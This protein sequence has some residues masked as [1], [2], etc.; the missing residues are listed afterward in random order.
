M[1]KS[2]QATLS[3]STQII[4]ETVGK[5]ADKRNVRRALLIDR[6]SGLLYELQTAYIYRNYAQKSLNTHRTILKNLAFFNEWISIKRNRNSKW[7]S[8]EE[9]VKNNQLALTRKE[10][11]DFSRW[12]QLF[13]HEVANTRQKETKSIRRIPTGKT[14]EARTT[15]IRLNTACNYLIWLT[16]EFIEG[17]LNLDDEYLIKSEKYKKIITSS[18]KRNIS[19]VKKPPP[20]LSLDDDESKIFRKTINS[21]SIFT[22]TPCGTR[23]RLIAYLFYFVGFRAGELLKIIC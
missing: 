6:N 1:N 2:G 19:S 18:F 17:S 11:D 9:R 10:I 4:V 3:A 21:F 13:A 23:D 20:I 8:P 5:G 7:L 16:E 14:V 12:S 15:N 22:D